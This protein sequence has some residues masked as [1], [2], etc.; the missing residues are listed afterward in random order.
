[1]VAPQ[2]PYPQS[3]PPSSSAGGTSKIIPVVVSAGLAVGVFAGLLF[4]LGT[5]EVAA[6]SGRRVG[7]GTGEVAAFDVGTEEYEGA[8]KVAVVTPD[9]GPVTPPVTPDGGVPATTPDGGTGTG[10]GSGSAAPA[11]KLAHITFTV[12]PAGTPAKITVDGKPVDGEV[13]ID[14]SAGAKSV[15]V[16][17]KAAGFRDFKKKI[18]VMKDDTQTIDLVKRPVGVPTNG[19]TGRRPDGSGGGKIDI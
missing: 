6:N 7:S 11:I 14:I 5:G 18:T 9:A 4:G 15:E 13:E 8:D 16:V 2:Q 12:T 1:M 17:A 10:S 19:N 3:P